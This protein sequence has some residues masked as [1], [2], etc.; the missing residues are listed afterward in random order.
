MPLE[1]A[2]VTSLPR[3]HGHAYAFADVSF[4]HACLM[5]LLICRHYARFFAAL[6]FSLRTAQ[7][8]AS[9]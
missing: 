3:H 2:A 9:A 6:L 8:F 5:P 7:L 1:R 4:R